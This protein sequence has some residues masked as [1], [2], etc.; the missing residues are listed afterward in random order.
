VAHS[1]PVANRYGVE[2]KSGSSGTLDGLLGDPA[3]FVQMGV[4]RDYF[5][6]TVGN[7]NERLFDVG[8][9]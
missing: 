1:Y 3:D 8:G 2:F 5:A 7:S 4:A 9:A 6:E